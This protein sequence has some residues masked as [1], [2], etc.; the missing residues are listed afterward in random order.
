MSLHSQFDRRR[1]LKTTAGTMTMLCVPPSPA[2]RT[3]TEAASS[4]VQTR[5]NHASIRVEGQK[6]WIETSTLTAILQKGF[7][8]SLKN[9]STGEEFL[10][11]FDIDRESPVQLVYRLNEVVGLDENRFGSTTC[12]QVS[13]NR[14]EVC[15]HSWDGDGVLSVM[16]D[17][18]NGDLVLEPSAYSSR[19]GA[20]ACRL[21]LT[22]LR[23]DLELV[24]PLFQGVRLRLDDSLIADR[25]WAWPVSWEAGLAVLQSQQGGFWVHAEDDRY[26][27][28]ALKTGS[29]STPNALGLDTEAY[30]PIDSNLGS[31]GLAWRFNVFHGDWK[32]PVSRYREW[33]WHAYSLDKEEKRR[34]D[35]IHGV[36]LALCWCPGNPEILDV[37]S[38]KVQPSKV[39]IHFPDWRT[40]PY[41]ENYPTF[42]PS[43]SGQAFI[44]KAQTMGYRIMP[45]CNSIDMD[46][47]H[48]VYSQ[49]RDF[50]YRDIEKQQ[51][52]GWA[53]YKGK[54]QGVPESNLTRLQHRDK[55]VMVKI[56]PGLSMWRSILGENI[57]GA[58]RTLS[59]QAV[60]I[61]VTLNTFNLH[62]CLVESMTP[63]EGMRRLIEQVAN[64]GDGLVVGGEGLNEITAQGLSFAQ[65][66]LFDSWHDTRPGLER[67]G[68]CPFNEFLFG[69]L[70]R[71][72]GYSGLGGRDQNEELRMRIHEE[73]GAIPTLTIDSPQEITHPNPTVKQILEKAATD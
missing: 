15:F 71:T 18:E 65:A 33:L 43:Q 23:P 2:T 56:H 61:D 41:D 31:G 62:N 3:V 26:R 8:T 9:K 1:F 68:G 54:S 34:K 59:L 16:A 49:V 35:W 45:H 72:I 20:L 46:P 22:G 70:C 14:A 63:T 50:Q 55:K 28:K 64:L 37:L 67:T 32:V 36:R 66:H 58:A 5:D 38:K 48:P 17:P 6:V 52:R 24:A 12:R 40:D 19:P 27:Y 53:W 69:K 47:I 11:P 44:T 51:L 13:R 30:G 25:R 21:W 39:V 10:Q 7:L 42:T 60:F 29:K 73:H 57:L 4:S